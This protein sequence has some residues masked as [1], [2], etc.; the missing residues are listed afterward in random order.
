MIQHLVFRMPTS[1][2]NAISETEEA[3]L[4]GKIT[5]AL[6][7]FPAGCNALVEVEV[8]HKRKKILPST[9]YGVVLDNTTQPFELDEEINI[10]DAIE[11][12]TKNHDNTYDHTIVVIVEVRE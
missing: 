11:V 9:R 10:G 4:T 12:I 7:H 3:P 6:I 5:R 1:S 2:L 8:W